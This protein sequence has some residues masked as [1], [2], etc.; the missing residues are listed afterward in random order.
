MRGPLCLQ[1]SA[2]YKEAH[3]KLDRAQYESDLNSDVNEGGKRKRHA[4]SR[5]VEEDDELAVVRSK[6]SRVVALPDTS[7]SEEIENPLHDVPDIPPVPSSFPQCYRGTGILESSHRRFAQDPQ[8]SINQTFNKPTTG[9]LEQMHGSSATRISGE[10]SASQMDEDMS[11]EEFR[12]QVLRLLHLI[13]ITQEGDSAVIDKLAKQRI[14]TSSLE[15]VEV[16]IKQ[17]FAT[18]EELENFDASLDEKKV[19]SRPG[20]CSYRW[21]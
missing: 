16:L 9:V 3:E 13:R 7:D 12:K 5:L 14:T 4:P 2:T 8:G 15:H 10:H 6:Y 1:F 18:S 21:K 19:S 11:T 20:A 17:P